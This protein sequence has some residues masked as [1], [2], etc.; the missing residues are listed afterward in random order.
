MSAIDLTAV[1]NPDLAREF[2][3]IA[4]QMSYAELRNDN[5]RYKKLFGLQSRVVSELKA[6][7]QRDVLLPLLEHKNRSVRLHAA[8]HTLAISPQRAQQTLETLQE[9]KSMPEAAEAGFTLLMLERGSF[10][11]D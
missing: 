9:T 1:P 2:E 5:R 11:P 7:G 10:I 6:R 3:E 4:I 8:K